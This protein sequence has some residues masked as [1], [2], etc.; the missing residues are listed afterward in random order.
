MLA[1][2][3]LQNPPARIRRFTGAPDTMRLMIG[4]ILGRRGE[5]S[6]YVRTMVEEAVRGLQDK[7]YLSEIIA[8]RNFVA[9]RVR[10]ANDQLHQ[11]M[12][13]DPQRLCEEIRAYRR[14]VGDCDDIASLMTTGGLCLGRVSDLVCVGFGAPGK[15]SHVFGRIKEPKSGKMLV[16][17][18]VAGTDEGKMLR[19][20]T[21]FQIWRLD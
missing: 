20:V 1:A 16:C 6:L 7:D 11:E 3:P 21:T 17:D 4:Q 15:Y 5:Q 13:K 10:Y 14:A 18:P 19:R 9:A 2:T 12:V 8:W